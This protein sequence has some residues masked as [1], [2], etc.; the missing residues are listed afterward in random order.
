MARSANGHVEH[1]GLELTVFLRGLWASRQSSQPIYAG[2][3]CRFERRAEATPRAIANSGTITNA[4]TRTA[5]DKSW[6]ISFQL[7]ITMSTSKLNTK[8]NDRST[9]LCPAFGRREFAGTLRVIC[10]VLRSSLD[11]SM[12]RLGS[13]G[14]IA[15]PMST[16]PPCMR[17]AHRPWKTSPRRA[18]T[19]KDLIL[20]EALTHVCGEILEG[21]TPAARDSPPRRG[22]HPRGEGES[23]G[24]TRRP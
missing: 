8:M 15:T 11:S 6:I 14:T 3:S 20:P 2:R 13:R 21:F 19:S 7:T 1:L 5:S 18:T 12:G 10:E 4:R 9:R 22:I 17:P 23:R 24:V 16:G